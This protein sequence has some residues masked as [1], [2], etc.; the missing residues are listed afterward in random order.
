MPNQCCIPSQDSTGHFIR[1]HGDPPPVQQP[2]PIQ[3]ASNQLQPIAAAV[4]EAANKSGIFMQRATHHQANPQQVGEP[5]EDD[6]EES[7]TEGLV[8]TLEI[9][10]P[11]LETFAQPPLPSTRPSI[12][13]HPSPSQGQTP[14]QPSFSQPPTPQIPPPA[15]AATNVDE[16]MQNLLCTLITLGQSTPQNLP[17]QTLAPVPL[18]QTCTCAPDTFD[19]SNPEDL[20]AFLLQCQIMFNAHPQNFTSESAKVFFTISYLKKSALEWSKQ[21]ILE[22]NL[23]QALEWRSSWT[24]FVKELWTHFRPANPTGAAEAEL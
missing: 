17:L 2:L 3:L 9:I 5:V 14:P 13:P 24:E 16:T 7:E 20:Q 4:Q 19:R 15:A 10:R 6:L 11:S 8:G 21:G 1:V 22:D 12:I 23:T 18:T